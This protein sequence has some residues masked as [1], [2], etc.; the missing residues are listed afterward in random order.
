MVGALTF[1][2]G[3]LGGA[4]VL[5]GVLHQL[6]A[7]LAR[8]AARASGAIGE[9]GKAGPRD[10]WQVLANGGVATAAIVAG[11]PLGVA[12]FAGAYAA[13]NADTW[14]TEI[15]MLARQAPRSILTGKPLA[16]GISGGVTL[17]GTLAEA[18][19]AVFIGT[20]AGRSRLPGSP[21]S[22]PLAVARRARRGC[23]ALSSTRC[24]AR[25]CRS[26]AGAPPANANARTIPTR[27]APAPYTIADSHGCRMTG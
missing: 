21:A 14:G 27:A 11:G 20:L 26:G 2:C 19:G 16:T 13:A 12:A 24:S 1:A 10:A 5:L 18:A 23:A 22:A 4:V 6:D 3:G 8:S 7:A 25:R 15:G 9:I 17:V